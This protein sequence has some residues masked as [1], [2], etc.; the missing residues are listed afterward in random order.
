MD[1]VMKG[2]IGKKLGMSQLFVE[3]GEV[4]PVTVVEAGPCKVLQVKTAERDGYEAVQLG[5]G[6]KPERLTNKP[7]QGHFKK[8]KANPYRSLK[9]FREFDAEYCEQ[10]KEV[11]ADIFKPGD[12][13]KVTGRTKGKGFQGV[14]R[15]YNFHGGPKTHGQSDR[16]RSPGSIGQSA[17]PSRV[18]KGLKMA[19]RTGGRITTTKNLV[20]VRVDADKNLLFIKGAIPGARNS[21]VTIRRQSN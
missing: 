20:V 7:L 8:A 10:G 12:K 21:I 1:R 6:E 5:F 15:R 4:L 2:I 19:G 13:V 14:I 18:F 17:D 16:L 9:E 11:K 3:T